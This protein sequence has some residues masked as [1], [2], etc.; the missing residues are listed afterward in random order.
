M[1]AG[2]RP[3]RFLMCL[4]LLLVIGCS[5]PLK[6]ESSFPEVTIKD[7]TVDEIELGTA[8]FLIARGY[9]YRGKDAVG[10]VFEQPLQGYGEEMYGSQQSPGWVRLRI[11]L[12]PKE[13]DLA[14]RMIGT[15]AI[16]T[17]VGSIYDEI[18]A[19]NTGNRKIQKLLKEIRSSLK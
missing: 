19:D 13:E 16:V 5:G 10:L 14:Y 18:A 15:G 6:T 1:I 7:L 12:V 3:I 2:M 4:V 17:S 8:Q 9:Q 11:H